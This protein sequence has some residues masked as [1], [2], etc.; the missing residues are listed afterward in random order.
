MLTDQ[1][2]QTYA[3]ERR[4]AV[5]RHEVHEFVKVRCWACAFLR[6]SFK[7]GFSQHLSLL[8]LSIAQKRGY[9]PRQKRSK[10]TTLD[11]FS[12]SSNA[13]VGVLA[14]LGVTQHTCSK[15]KTGQ[16][17]SQVSL[18]PL[19]RSRATFRRRRPRRRTRRLR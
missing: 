18:S 15:P 9:V 13:A 6:S 10:D 4:Q 11:W 17:P 14:L 3:A 16:T 1:Q 5:G 12:S 19:P 7:T 2:G 8:P